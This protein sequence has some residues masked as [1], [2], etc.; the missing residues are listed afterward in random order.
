MREWGDHMIIRAFLRRAALTVPSVGRFYTYA[1]ALRSE[2][3]GLA[4]RC[5][6]LEED[7]RR[8]TSQRDDLAGELD[9]AR[10]A[11]SAAV[12]AREQAESAARTVPDERETLELRLYTLTSDFQRAVSASEKLR[13]RLRDAERKLEALRRETG[14]T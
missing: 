4:S 1:Q 7:G 14:R 6:E 2:R 10:E 11:L 3:D 12:T 5:A 9:R 13:A 8:L